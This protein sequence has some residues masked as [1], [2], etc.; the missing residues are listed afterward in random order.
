MDLDTVPAHL[1]VL[2]G[3]HIGLEFGQIV[4]RFGSEVTIIQCS[5]QLLSREGRQM[6]RGVSNASEEKN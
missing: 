3:S 6:C 5:R 1:L 2:G 4:W